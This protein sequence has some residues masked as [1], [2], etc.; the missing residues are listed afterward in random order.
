MTVLKNVC[1]VS[2]LAVAVVLGV[3]LNALLP[4]LVTPVPAARH[5]AAC[6]RIGG[7]SALSG[8][9]DGDV[10]GDVALFTSD[11]RRAWLAQPGSRANKLRQGPQGELLLLRADALRVLARDERVL[12]AESAA[13][14]TFHPHGLHLFDGAHGELLAGVVNHQVARRV[15]VPRLGAIAYVVS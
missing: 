3:L 12:D 5:D 8:C 10:R 14:R 1:N 4:S 9:E 15:C 11:A 2:V 6:A 13:Q 7:G